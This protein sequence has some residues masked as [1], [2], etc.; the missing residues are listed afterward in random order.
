[1]MD[2]VIGMIQ[3]LI[4]NN[5]SFSSSIIVESHSGHIQKSG[6]QGQLAGHRI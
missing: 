2:V 5:Y 3:S 4:G 1:M 6:F